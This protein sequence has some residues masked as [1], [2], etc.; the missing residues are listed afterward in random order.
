MI[1]PPPDYRMVKLY[2]PHN[3]EQCWMILGPTFQTTSKIFLNHLFWNIHFSSETYMGTQTIQISEDNFETSHETPQ[4]SI[5]TVNGRSDRS[6]SWQRKTALFSGSRAGKKD[7]KLTRCF[8][9]VILGTFW[10]FFL[11]L[12]TWTIRLF[13]ET[14]PSNSFTHTCMYIYIYSTPRPK[15]HP[16]ANFYRYLGYLFKQLLPFTKCI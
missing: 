11:I 12:T 4:L 8:L 15:T 6:F 13:W 1:E 10:S 3:N 16:F 9:D 14:Y 5:L 7:D 2:F